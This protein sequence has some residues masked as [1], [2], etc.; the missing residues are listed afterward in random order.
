MAHAGHPLVGDPVYGGP[1]R[2]RAPAAAIRFGRQALHAQLIGFVHPVSRERLRFES[3]LPN[4]ISEL[5]DLLD[6]L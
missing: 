1:G 4:D 6:R 2:K 5:I 3:N